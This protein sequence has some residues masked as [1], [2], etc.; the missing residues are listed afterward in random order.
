MKKHLSILLIL[1]IAFG[2][3]C[4]L[5]ACDP[6]AGLDEVS[7]EEIANARMYST[8]DVSSTTITYNS[9]GTGTSTSSDPDTMSGA[10]VK[11]A[12]AASKLAIET[13]KIVYPKTYGDVYANKDYS[14]IVVYVYYRKSDDTLTSKSITTYTKK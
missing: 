12:I 14:K 4:T 10:A 7:F 3:I 8:Y 5:T 6:T 1:A 2:A 9:E 11:S 13:S